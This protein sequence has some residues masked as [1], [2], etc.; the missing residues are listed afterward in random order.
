MLIDH[1]RAL[2]AHVEAIELELRVSKEDE[3]EAVRRCGEAE[4]SIIRLN[5]QV[6]Q[7]KRELGESRA[8]ELQATMSADRLSTENDA[9]KAE[10]ESKKVVLPKEVAEDLEARLKANQ[11]MIYSTAYD[12][13]HNK[14]ISKH[15]WGWVNRQND[16]NLITIAIVNGYTV[17]EPPTTEDKMRERFEERLIHYEIKAGID[18][19]T[20]AAVLAHE[21]RE[22]LA[23][24]RQEE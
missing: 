6:M 2:V 5:Q 4:L 1:V 24:E 14:Y 18:N 21:V 20:L 16:C 23:E 9:L 22:V 3:E 11:G 13:V 17:E 12:F 8:D 7:L 15:T 19:K 10:L